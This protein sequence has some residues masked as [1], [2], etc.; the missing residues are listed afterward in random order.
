MRDVGFMED[1]SC[2][3]QVGAGSAAYRSLIAAM[4]V[5]FLFLPSAFLVYMFTLLMT[6]LSVIPMARLCSTSRKAIRR[7]Q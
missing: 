2:R 4:D 3:E 1:E 7:P 5:T 6:A